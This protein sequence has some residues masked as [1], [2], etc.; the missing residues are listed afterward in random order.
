V[1]KGTLLPVVIAAAVLVTNVLHI[2]W[3]SYDV[4]LSVEPV[5]GLAMLALLVLAHRYLFLF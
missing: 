2:I 3:L 5:T 1:T 4:G